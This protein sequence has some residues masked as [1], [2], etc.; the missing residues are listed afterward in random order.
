MLGGREVGPTLLKVL[1]HVIFDIVLEI[2]VHITFRGLVG[3]I[4]GYSV[5]ARK[6]GLNSSRLSS[7]SVILGRL[8]LR[9][10]PRNALDKAPRSREGSFRNR[11]MYGSIAV[12][13]LG[14]VR[15]LDLVFLTRR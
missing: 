2:V 15:A 14:G 6:F 7:N 1:F 13:A 5:C 12:P 9:G 4:D 8:F 10:L 11:V 3:A